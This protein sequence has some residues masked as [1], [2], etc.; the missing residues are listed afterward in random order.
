MIPFKRQSWAMSLEQYDE[1]LTVK[2]VSK[3]RSKFVGY[4]KDNY[5]SKKEYN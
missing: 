5:W 3:L 2:G 1:E 4:Y